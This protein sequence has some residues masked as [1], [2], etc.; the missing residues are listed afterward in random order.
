MGYLRGTVGGIDQQNVPVP[1]PGGLQHRPGAVVGLQGLPA[2]ENAPAE[3]DAAQQTAD[4]AVG[5]GDDAAVAEGLVLEDDR[6]E[7]GTEF[8]ILGVGGGVFPDGVDLLLL[9]P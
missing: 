1:D 7:D 4:L 5:E 6:V 9:R 2:A 8:G 3:L